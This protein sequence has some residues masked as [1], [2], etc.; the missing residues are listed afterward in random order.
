MAKAIMGSVLP[1]M[2]LREKAGQLPLAPGVYLYRDAAGR[3]IYV[4]KA[5]SLRLR[6]RSYFSEDKLADTSGTRACARLSTGSCAMLP[7]AKRSYT[8]FYLA[9]A[10]QGPLRVGR[11]APGGPGERPDRLRPGVRSAAE[12][13]RLQDMDAVLPHPGR[14]R[15]RWAAP[16]CSSNAKIVK[17]NPKAK[18]IS[19]S[20][21]QAVY[22]MEKKD[23][24]RFMETQ[25]DRMTL[26]DIMRDQLKGLKAPR[27]GTKKEDSHD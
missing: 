18:K 20:F 6:V 26:G 27:R 8:C 25:N 9:R 17:M 24:Q 14:D 10:R 15:R 5:K 7:S 3:V 16:A 23:F 1:P 19:L 13:F 12:R 2:E 21:K 4:G 11:L 22:D